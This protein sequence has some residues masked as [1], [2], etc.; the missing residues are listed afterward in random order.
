MWGL[1]RNLS[2]YLHLKSGCWG[3]VSHHTGIC[4]WKQVSRANLWKDASITLL[5]HSNLLFS[6][7]S[8]ACMLFSYC[9]NFSLLTFVLIISGTWHGIYMVTNVDE[10]AIWVASKLLFLWK[11]EMLINVCVYYIC[12]LVYCSEKSKIPNV[13]AQRKKDLYKVTFYY[14]ESEFV[15]FRSQ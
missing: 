11:G 2:F 13:K 9:V 15:C 7:L 6:F 8:S 1:G 14:F 3:R 4:A 10:V 12:C 5:G